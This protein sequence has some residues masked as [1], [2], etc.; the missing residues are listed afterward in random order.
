MKYTLVIFYVMAILIS[1]N[2]KEKVPQSEV[3]E[4]II[5]NYISD[6]NL[7]AIATGTGLYYVKENE[8][9]GVKPD[10]TSTVTVAY[11]G[12]LTDGYVFDEST[13]DG[14]TFPLTNVISGW[15]E[16][17]PLFKEGGKGKLLIPSGLGYG[18]Q[19][20][21]DIPKNAV[22]IFDVELIKVM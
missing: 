13:L 17:I 8:G 7:T 19:G 4:N 22:L 5:K 3:D 21:G 6:K 12:Y 14:A 16:G 2:G 1:C 15:Q 9:T 18:S 11:K 20:N 10:I